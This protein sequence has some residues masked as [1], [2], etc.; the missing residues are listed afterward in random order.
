MKPNKKLAVGLAAAIA[1]A[2]VA[3]IGTASPASAF[4]PQSVTMPGSLFLGNAPATVNATTNNTYTDTYT[5]TQSPANPNAGQVVT[6]TLAGTTGPLTGPVPLAANVQ[7]VRA[8]VNVTGAQSATVA[9]SSGGAC[10]YP[11]APVAAGGNPQGPWTTTGTYT[12]TG[13][14]SA[15]ISMNQLFFD[16]QGNLDGS[17]ANQC[18]GTANNADYYVSAVSQTAG[19]GQPGL[20]K[21]APQNS[22]VVVE[23]FTITGPNASVTAVTGQSV[24]TAVR[25]GTGGPPT[26]ATAQVSVTGTVWDASI[27]SGGFTAAYCNVAGTVCDAATPNTLSTDASGNISGNIASGATASSVT[28]PRAIKIIETVSGDEALVPITVLGTPTISI[29]PS[30][31]GAGTVVAVT[32]NNFNPSQQ[33]SVSSSILPGPPFTASADAPL[34]NVGTASAIGAIPSTN[35]TVNDGDTQSILVTQGTPGAPNITNP[36]GFA[37]FTFSGDEC[38]AYTDNSSVPGGD[39]S[40][41][42][43]NGCVLDFNVDATILAG[44]LRMQAFQTPGNPTSTAITLGSIQTSV[45]GGNLPG[46]LNDIVVTDTRGGLFGWSLTAEMDDLLSGTDAMADDLLEVDPACAIEVGATGSAA[47]VTDGGVQNFGSTVTLCTKDG[48]TDAISDST[49]GQYR[50]TGDLDLTVPPFQAAGLY[51]SVMSITLA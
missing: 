8:T 1:M 42:G 2:G 12:A 28:G 38:T 23:N 17:A 4:G 34:I 32:G 51:T 39:G 45:T 13:N 9:L 46:V 49:S 37:G 21:T 6:V 40:T 47:G 48:T 20:T 7:I 16:D 18:A 25:L 15:A 30:S 26:F 11:A 19:S 50:V 14:G 22:P 44:D 35:F 36:A 43:V 3:A 10:N 5:L 33:Y 31:G 29:S 24:T 27:G 41:P